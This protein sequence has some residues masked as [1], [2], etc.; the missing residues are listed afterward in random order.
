MPPHVDIYKKCIIYKKKKQLVKNSP[1]LTQL[2]IN[3]WIELELGWEK[4][5]KN[6]VNIASLKPLLKMFF[7]LGAFS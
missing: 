6:K 7:Y 4:K 3:A 5:T 1:T 2:L